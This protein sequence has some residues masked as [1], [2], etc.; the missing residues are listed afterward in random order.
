MRVHPL[1]IDEALTP[2]KETVQGTHFPAICMIDKLINAF[3]APLLFL[4]GG[5]GLEEGQRRKKNEKRD[6]VRKF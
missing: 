6:A 1:E 5:G 2:N 4:G 3:H